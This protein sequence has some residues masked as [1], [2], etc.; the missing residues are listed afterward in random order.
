[1]TR[2]ALT[3]C[4]IAAVLAAA[5]ARAATNVDVRIA[6]SADDAEESNSGSV[7]LTSTDLELVYD[8]SNQTVGLRFPGLN[9]PQ[10]AEVLEA[11][12]QFEADETSSSAASVQ[13]QAQAADN[14]PTF[15]TA[16]NN[17]SS[18]ARALGTVPWIPPPWTTTGVAGP[19]QRTPNLAALI[20][21]VVDR[22]GWAPGN[23]LALLI[24]GTNKR[25]AESYNGRA[26]GAPLLHVAYALPEVNDPPA[27]SVLSPAHRSQFVSGETVPLQATADDPE[28]GDLGDMLLWV[29]SRDGIVAQGASAELTG[30][31][32]G[33]HTLTAHAT[34]FDG[35]RTSVSVDVQI[36]AEGHV[37]VG[38]GDIAR[39]STTNAS[40]ATAQL[41]DQT[42]GG[43]FTLGDNAYPDGTA[44]EYA[45]CYGPTWGRHRARTRPSAG[46]HEYHVADA[47]AYFDYFG[48]AAGDPSQGWYSYEVG[49]W[50]VV[51][52]NSNC[53]EIGGCTASSP[54]AQWLSADLTAHP[55]DCTLAMWHHPRFS[56]GESHGSHTFMA[57]FWT[58]LQQHGADL[59]LAGHEHLYERFAPQNAQGAADPLGIRQFTVGTGGAGLYLFDPTLPNSEVRYNGGFGVLKLTLHDTS[60]DWSFL[61]VAGTTFTDSGSASCVM[62]GGPGNHPPSVQITAPAAGA[63]FVV[64]SP[65]GFAATAADD[66]DGSL[67]AAL[68]WSSDR[69]GALGFGAAFTTSALSIGTHVVTA[70]VSDT[71]GL[72][73]SAQRSIVVA[74]A[75]PT[76]QMIE[77]RIPTGPDDAEEDTSTRDMF[78]GSADLELGEDAGDQYVGLRFT[79][80]AIPQGARIT[81]AWLQFQADGSTST[82]TSVQVFGHDTDDAP[83]FTRTDR[84]ISNRARTAATVSWAPAAW[85]A[86]QQGPAQRTPSLVALIQE[87]VDRSGW[88]PGRDLVLIVE[89][90][91]GLRRAQSYEG[92]RLSAP[93]LHVEYTAP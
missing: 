29:S 33:I 14:A 10:G 65:V 71:G 26:A 90:V 70:S 93:L 89:G 7:L 69:D 39:C 58:I 49:A 64:G 55:S 31:S 17:V 51:V 79:A 76:T 85:G 5:S 88:A 34:D 11:W 92:D 21:A 20:Q 9:V 42:F 24:T 19:A 18:R 91:S 44:A 6:A 15:T 32:V 37:L 72:S 67:S 45:G 25:T 53:A 68:A 57:P 8:G 56:S 74:P 48:A 54:Q 46:N 4:L 81:D 77:Q 3:S 87:I 2:L 47:A 41:L 83:A 80:L 1:M 86:G 22:P 38:A 61:P 40:E 59:T 84:D 27:V 73:A 75:T 36:S 28:D 82:S 30:L 60:Y 35:L 66:E 13:I 62:A 52:L 12:V 16:K 43:V 78:L 63:S 23:A 50:H